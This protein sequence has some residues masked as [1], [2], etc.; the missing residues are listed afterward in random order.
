MV[1]RHEIIEPQRQ[2]RSGVERVHRVT[3]GGV[4]A[5]AG[6]LDDDAVVRLHYL[7]RQC[8]VLSEGARHPLP[9]LFPQA[10]AA[11]DVRE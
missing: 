11:F 3:E 5:V 1:L 4:H 7:A 8:I 10:G 9:L 2:V 6:H